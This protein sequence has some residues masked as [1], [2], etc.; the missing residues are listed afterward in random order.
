MISIQ[1]ALPLEVHPDKEMAAQLQAE[2]RETQ[3]GI[4]SLWSQSD[5]RC[6]RGKEQNLCLCDLRAEARHSQVSF[7][8]DHALLSVLS[9]TNARPPAPHWVLPHEPYHLARAH[10]TQA[11]HPSLDQFVV[12]G[13]GSCRAHTRSG[14][15]E[16]EVQWLALR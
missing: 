5:R 1:K 7:V 10:R 14:W 6:A 2:D 8:D 15:F 13:M 4:L 11:Y 9:F 16:S 3:A 12:L